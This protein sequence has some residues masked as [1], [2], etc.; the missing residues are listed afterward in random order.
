MCGLL[1]HEKNNA[2][3]SFIGVEI[4]SIRGTLRCN[5]YHLVK[6]HAV[7]SKRTSTRS[8]INACNFSLFVCVWIYVY[9]CL[10]FFFFF[11]P[12]CLPFFFTLLIVDLT[13]YNCIENE[14]S[15]DDWRSKL[16]LTLDRYLLCTF[17][18]LSFTDGHYYTLLCYFFKE[19]V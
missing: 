5:V 4:R 13:R 11:I 16:A 18:H 9:A 1:A 17:M 6:C 10:F 14:A 7:L 15:E 12:F 8:I 3:S 2:F 19:R